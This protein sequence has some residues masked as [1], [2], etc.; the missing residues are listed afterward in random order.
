MNF[1]CPKCH[2][3]YQIVDHLKLEEDY[4]LGGEKIIKDIL[5]EKQLSKNTI[6]PHASLVIVGFPTRTL[7]VL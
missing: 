5:E 4:Q 3:K 6:L 2:K 1:F 7:C